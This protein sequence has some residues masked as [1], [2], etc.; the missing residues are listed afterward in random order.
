MLVFITRLI[1]T[2]RCYQK[3]TVILLLR[4]STVI[5]LKS[6]LK[7]HLNANSDNCDE[8]ALCWKIQ[9]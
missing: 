1:E 2:I 8:D 9:N 6:H 5:S 3:A 4:S 7:F